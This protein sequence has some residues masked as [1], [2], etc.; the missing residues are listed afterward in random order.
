[1]DEGKVFMV[2]KAEGVGTRVQQW[3]GG[4]GLMANPHAV[5]A[6]S[7]SRPSQDEGGE[8]HIYDLCDFEG[9]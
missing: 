5:Q 9:S 7:A 4:G 2:G 8:G 6:S 3:G 1:M